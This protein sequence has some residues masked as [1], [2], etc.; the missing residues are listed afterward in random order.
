[1]KRQQVCGAHETGQAGFG[2][3]VD[4]RHQIESQQRQVSQVV[5]RERL[6]AQVRMNAA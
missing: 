1:M 4:S 2:I 3:Y 6:A 5:L